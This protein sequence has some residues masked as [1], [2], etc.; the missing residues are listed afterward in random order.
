MANWPV[1]QARG[2]NKWNADWKGRNKR[3]N[4][5]HRE[6]SKESTTNCPVCPKK[7]IR[8]FSEDTGTTQKTNCS[9]QTGIYYVDTKTENTMPSTT[10][11]KSRKKHLGASLTNFYRTY[12]QNP[13]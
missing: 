2:G 9:L 13:K 6:K 7:L 5:C 12:I 10:T 8:E 1:Q 11:Q 4:D 3:W